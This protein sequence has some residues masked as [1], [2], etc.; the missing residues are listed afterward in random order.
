LLGRGKDDKRF[1]VEDE[2][3]LVEREPKTTLCE[4]SSC[5]FWHNE[6][7]SEETMI[8]LR[9]VLAVNLVILVFSNPVSAQ[10]VKVDVSACG[11]M[12]KVLNAMRNGTSLHIS[13]A[14]LDT[15]LDTK[16]Y[17][18]MFRHYNRPYR[19]NYLPRRVFRNMILSLA[20]EGQYSL[21]EN[22]RADQMLPRWR[23]F[24]KDLLLYERNLLQLKT[25]DLEKLINVGVGYAQSWLPPE[26]VI[27]DFSFY[28]LPCG[29]TTAFALA[30][31][32]G[33]DFFQLLR[34]SSGNITWE[35]LIAAISHES[36]HLGIRDSLP[37][38][39]TSSDSLALSFI[40]LFVDEGTATK[41][42]DNAPGG[43]VPAVA[44]SRGH[45]FEGEL[46][47]LWKNYTSEEPDIFNRVIA[48]FEKLYS[49]GMTAEDLNTEAR[50]YWLSGLKGRA[51]FLG[52]ELFGAVYHAF[53]KDGSFAAMR[54][55]R[56]LFGLY[57]EAIE[58]KPDLLGSCCRIPEST[59]EHALAIGQPNR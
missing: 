36:H 25:A 53:G 35:V 42:V 50:T 26:W 30:E 34:D 19:P 28:V 3:S 11:A 56:K 8:S 29:G 6:F 37:A 5:P 10:K 16:P 58:K 12:F 14:M 20:Y 52:S 7:Q 4:D 13:S 43:C 48:V 24:Y 38:S 55:P 21:G 57:N 15:V 2:R 22:R 39:M 54:D 40:S 51:Y 23:E 45:T 18:A 9:N 31:A 1:S 32:Q 27:P 41:F 33:Y 46:G 49:G 44:E 17:E 47:T 59:V